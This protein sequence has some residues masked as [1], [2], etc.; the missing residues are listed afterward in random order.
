M[1]REMSHEKKHIIN[2]NLQGITLQIQ[3]Q[4]QI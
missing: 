3:I 1:K 2:Y 4:I